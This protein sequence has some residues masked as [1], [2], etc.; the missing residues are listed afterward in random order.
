[1]TFA[2]IFDEY[3]SQYRGQA[4]SIPVYGDREFT[5]AVRLANNAIR[6]WDRVDGVLWNELYTRATDQ[7]V[8]TW[9]T[10]DRTIVDGT[11]SY[12]C[13]SNMRKPPKS[14]FLYTGTNYIDLPVIDAIDLAGLSELSNAVTFLGS[15]N[16]GYTMYI[17][18]AL[19]SQY[20]GRGI[21]YL[22]YRKPTLL[23]T[24]TD[25]SA[26]E[27]D[28]SDPNFMIQDMLVGRFT[29][30]RNGFGVKVADAQAKAA[31]MNM[32]IENYSGQQGKSDN[33]GLDGGW[34]INAPVN[35]IKLT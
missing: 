21:D 24:S 8:G 17:T 33:I 19:S 13:P 6:K 29:Q 31:L 35:D 22:Y 28:M 4:T 2:E 10:A 15:A 16:T 7:V 34:G 25:P 20:A 11:V 23:S 14:V 1:M 30:S 18:A 5:V 32:K 26:T 27:P 12:A 3:F 9:A